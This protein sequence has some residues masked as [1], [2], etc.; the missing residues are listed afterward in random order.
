MYLKQWQRSVL[1]SSLN[2]R[3]AM[4]QIVRI[5]IRQRNNVV[6]TDPLQGEHKLKSELWL[7][8]VEYY[9]KFG[10]TT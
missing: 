4:V 6:T 8:S 5:P 1:N 2:I 3:L 10:D 9:Y 7:F